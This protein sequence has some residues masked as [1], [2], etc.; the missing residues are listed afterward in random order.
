[1]CSGPRRI[2]R[3]PIREFSILVFAIAICVATDAIAQLDAEAEFERGNV[4]FKQGKYATARIAYKAATRINPDHGRAWEQL[5]ITCKK[6][7]KFED[8]IHAFEKARD[9]RPRDNT[10][11]WHLWD[12]TNKLSKPRKTSSLEPRKSPTPKVK[13][14]RKTDHKG[15]YFGVGIGGG[16]G[17]IR[18]TNQF[19]RLGPGDEWPGLAL[20][21]QLG[22]GATKNV[23]LLLSTYSLYKKGNFWAN[24]VLGIQSIEFYSGTIKAYFLQGTHQFAIS[25]GVGRARMRGFFLEKGKLLYQGDSGTGLSA[26]LAY[27]IFPHLEIE[28]TAIV[29]FPKFVIRSK[30]VAGRLWSGILSLNFVLF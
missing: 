18:E 5:G 16:Y 30:D 7:G 20:R 2:D 29:G 6:L 3:T 15:P 17:S 27:V 21:L 13:F 26:G 1:M 19:D 12:A 24:P 4:F 9:I 28:A 14:F 23:I 10:L 11:D 22:Y 8:A 25:A